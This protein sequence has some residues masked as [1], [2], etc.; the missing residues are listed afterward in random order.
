MR[1]HSIVLTCLLLLLVAACGN[2]PSATSLPTPFILVTA[3]ADSTPTMTPFQPDDFIPPTPAQATDQPIINTEEATPT[4]YT[5]PFYPTLQTQPVD[6]LTPE[7]VTLLPKPAGQIS[8]LLLGSDKRAD[9]PSFRTDVMIYMTIKPDGSISMVSFPRDMFVYIPGFKM[10]RMNGAFL[11]GGYDTLALTLEYNFGILPDF[12]VMT[13]FDG[14]ISMVDSLGGVEVDAATSFYDT[15]T[16]YPNGYAIDPGI[17]HMDGETAL[18]YVRSRKSTSDFDRLRRAQEVIVAIGQKLLSL[19]ALTRI[20]EFYQA[21]QETVTTNVNLDDLL[22]NLPTLQHVDLN[23]V[24]RYT[25]GL[26]YTTVWIE[27]GSGAYYLIPH[28][29]DI[30]Q[31]L[32]QAIGVP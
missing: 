30:Q 8:I 6:T 31:V 21:F 19:N 17:V 7:P 22:R 16:G 20:P 12:Y 24:D 5:L 2:N 10:A 27:P 11:Y 29:Y 1:F 18:W 32:R 26:D 25:I 23:R 9:S 14:F 3:P 28:T 4:L 13:N 15:R